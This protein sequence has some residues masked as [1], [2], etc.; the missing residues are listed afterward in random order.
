VKM[1]PTRIGRHASSASQRQQRYTQDRSMGSSRRGRLHAPHGAARYRHDSRLT[2]NTA[3]SP[4]QL[5]RSNPWS[6]Y[7]CASIVADLQ[8]SDPD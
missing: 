2:T 7:S 5:G 4:V 1:P 8:R 3:A 6:A